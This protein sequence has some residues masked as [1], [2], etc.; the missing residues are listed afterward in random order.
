[1]LKIKQGVTD[2]DTAGQ[3]D[4]T[5]ISARMATQLSDKLAIKASFSHKEGTDWSAQD[6][7]HSVNGVIFDDYPTNAPD[8][9]AVNEEGEIAFEPTRITTSSVS[10]SMIWIRL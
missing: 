1:M 3:N 6:Y 9:N 2:Q 5:E 4:F 7:R 8:Y 10:S